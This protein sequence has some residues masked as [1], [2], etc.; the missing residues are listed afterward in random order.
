MEYKRVETKEV[1][2]AFNLYIFNFS[3]G[4]KKEEL[5]VAFY[6][7]FDGVR[8]D[9][10]DGQKCV[11]IPFEK[12][13]ELILQKAPIYHTD[14]TKNPPHEVYMWFYLMNKLGFS[15]FITL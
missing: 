5:R 2:K 9:F 4:D 15:R 14:H 7:E 6:A 8:L 10:A 11:D 1:N 12:A 13:G 3:N